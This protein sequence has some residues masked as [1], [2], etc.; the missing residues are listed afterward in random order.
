MPHADMD[1]VSPSIHVLIRQSMDKF[2][3][4]HNN[5]FLVF[6]TTD[7]CRNFQ[8]TSS[9]PSFYFRFITIVDVFLHII[10]I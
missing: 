8:T 6:E 1:I 10:M 3:S 7:V 5:K 4:M 9:E 2:N